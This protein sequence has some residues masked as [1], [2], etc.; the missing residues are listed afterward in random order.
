MWQKTLTSRASARPLTLARHQA[1][2]ACSDGVVINGSTGVNNI[3]HPVTNVQRINP[4]VL[5]CQLLWIPD[6]VTVANVT[7]AIQVAYGSLTALLNDP[8]QV[9]LDFND[10]DLG[11][12][13]LT[14][15]TGE[16]HPG[17][18]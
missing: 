8:G 12:V 3:S 1:V 11:K 5:T 2:C 10:L 9:D 7:N 4:N 14:C 15:S 6:N 13:N 18:T 16:I 17:V